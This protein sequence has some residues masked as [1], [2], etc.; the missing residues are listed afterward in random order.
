M[1][2]LTDCPRLSQKR[3]ILALQAASMASL[4]LGFYLQVDVTM[5]FDWSTHLNF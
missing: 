3:T 1:T 2:K 4:S 5:S